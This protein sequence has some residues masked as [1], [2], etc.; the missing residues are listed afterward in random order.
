[1]ADYIFGVLWQGEGGLDFLL[2]LIFLLKNVNVGKTDLE[3]GTN[4][5][6]MLWG[7]KCSHMG[8]FNHGGRLIWHPQCL[9]PPYLEASW[10]QSPML[11]YGKQRTTSC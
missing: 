4:W 6:E 11:L 5:L 10:R 1:M 9:R 7:I 3:A 8:K 2:G